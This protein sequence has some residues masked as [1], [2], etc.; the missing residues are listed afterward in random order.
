VYGSDVADGEDTLEWIARQAWSN[1]RVG[2]SGS[3]ACATTALAAA[4]SGHPS[5]RAFFAQV[6]ASSIYDD[7]VYEGRS[8]ELERA[9]SAQPRLS[10]PARTGCACP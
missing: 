1:Q 2:L 5:A 8:I 10:S 4:S 9:C 3:S 7:V 6:G